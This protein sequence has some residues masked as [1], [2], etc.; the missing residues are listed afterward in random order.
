VPNVGT[1]VPATALDGARMS[2]FDETCGDSGNT[3][4]VPPLAIGQ[5]VAMAVHW[6]ASA[7]HVV[8]A[9]VAEHAVT[10]VTHFVGSGGHV[11]DTAG[12]SVCFDT[13]VVTFGGQVVA[14]AGHT[15]VFDA[16]A[17]GLGGQVVATAGQTVA[18]PTHLVSSGGHAVDVIGQRVCFVGHTVILIGHVVAAVG[19]I[20]G[21]ATGGTGPLGGVAKAASVAPNTQHTVLRTTTHRNVVFMAHPLL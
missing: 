8:I 14:A 17:V 7:G 1:L 3:H 12:Q 11:V 16:Q 4:T 21:R 18:L 13:Q 2:P 6:V 9:G 10:T 19:N 20:V 5:T 15:V